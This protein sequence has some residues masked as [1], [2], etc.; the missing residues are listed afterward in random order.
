VEGQLAAAA[1]RKPEGVGGRGT[2]EDDA[3]PTDR[4]WLDPV[5]LEP[6]AGRAQEEALLGGIE[7]QDGL[8]WVAEDKAETGILDASRGGGEGNGLG[9]KGYV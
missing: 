5:E 1:Q 4:G 9:I 6:H 3:F 2:L 8:R 7:L